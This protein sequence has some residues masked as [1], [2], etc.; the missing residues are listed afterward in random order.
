[1]LRASVPASLAFALGASL[2]LG[3]QAPDAGAAPSG[4]AAVVALGSCDSPA[5]A[6][7]ARTF[8][9]LLAARMGTG[10]QSEV[11]SAAPLGG[12]ATRTLTDVQHAVTE[13]RAA[14]YKGK[15]SA[16]VTALEG[17]SNEVRR[18]PPG[19][20]R[21]AVERDIWTL[22]AQARGKGA[23]A[24]DAL[25][26][27]FRVEPDYQPD[28]ALYPPSFRKL[29]DGVRKQQARA[30]TSRLDVAISPPG[31]D[32]YVDGRKLGKAPVSLRLPAGSYR[33]EADF[34]RRSLARTVQIPEPPALA[35]P[36]ELGAEVEGALYADGGP[37]LE[38]GK[39]RAGALT[40]AA[41]LLGV[42]RLFGLHAEGPPDR[43]TLELGVLDRTGAEVAEARMRLS[44]G[45]PETEA[46]A[47]LADFAATGRIAPG[48]EVTKGGGQHP[49]TAVE[50]HLVGQLLGTP[51]PGGFNLE[52]Y[53]V[54]GHF[55]RETMHFTGARFELPDVPARRTVLHVVTDDGRVALAVADSTRGE[56]R[57]DL[58]L[59]QPCVVTGM[60]RDETG[61]PA[62]GARVFA[63]LR[64]SGAW[65][66]G[67]A[68][69]R[70]RFVVKELV[71]GDYELFAGSARARLS[72][73]RFTLAGDCRAELPAV[74]VPRAALAVDGE[75]ASR[76]P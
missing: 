76:E 62:G 14:F 26:H 35:P 72:V 11:D 49:P 42:N 59:E 12:L 7:S 54:E 31:T 57:K 55:V 18:L 38:P 69:P 58:T 75:D 32:V 64:A 73:A 17:L 45:Q 37:C 9:T 52:A 66:A 27:V 47:P 28:T 53:G 3:A 10:L 33:I 21:W 61:R 2:V 65:R 5:S 46:L 60:V 25:R 71:R 39:D 24:E 15:V 43:R 16:A 68:G 34:G 41:A 74:V 56:T 20:A 1:M 40:R 51:P 4:S 13:A 19:D 44:A 30:P 29:A 6:I 36:V 48:V 67:K 70:G 22:L 50:G 8:R 23:Q 63:T